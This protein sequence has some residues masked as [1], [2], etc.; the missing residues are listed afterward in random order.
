MDSGNLPY[1]QGSQEQVVAGPEALQGRYHHKRR[2]PRPSRGVVPG[3]DGSRDQ[4]LLGSG[5]GTTPAEEVVVRTDRVSKGR[6]SNERTGTVLG[7]RRVLT[8]I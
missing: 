1:F 4:S 2:S 5:P 6:S 7:G 8:R 3:A